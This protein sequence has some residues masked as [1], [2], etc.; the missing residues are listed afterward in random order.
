MII[1]WIKL[2]HLTNFGI[3]LFWRNRA[4]IDTT[5]QVWE[6][7]VSVRDCTYWTNYAQYIVRIVVLVFKLSLSSPISA[8]HH[9]S[10]LGGKVSWTRKRGAAAMGFSNVIHTRCY[11]FINSRQEC[12]HVLYLD[13]VNDSRLLYIILHH[14]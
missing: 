10:N 12:I 7:R 2:E 8:C 4:C 13:C 9:I 3:I 6:S 5:V 14:L 1:L 11:I